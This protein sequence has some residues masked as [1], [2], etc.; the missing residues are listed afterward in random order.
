MKNPTRPPSLTLKVPKLQTD[1]Y[2]MPKET[3]KRNHVPSTTAYPARKAP[4]AEGDRVKTLRMI[5]NICTGDAIAKTISDSLASATPEN[6]RALRETLGP[7]FEEASHPLH[8]VRCHRSFIQS[9]NHK[10][11]C[12]VKC[13]YDPEWNQE[14]TMEDEGYYEMMC[15]GKTFTKYERPDNVCFKTLHTTNPKEVEY[16]KG[17]KDD[18]KAGL[19]LLGHK[20]R[21]YLLYKQV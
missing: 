12:L 1:I 8:C 11:A 4:P 3:K 7:L 19:R 6:L 15:Y 5:L 14:G 9:G 13:H 20:R 10:E 21:G 17:D 2:P 16:R 18:Q